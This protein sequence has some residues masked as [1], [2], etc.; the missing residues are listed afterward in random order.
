[1]KR[2]IAITVFIHFFATAYSQHT[3]CNPVNIDYRYSL[4]RPSRREAADPT[5]I[6]FK[7]EYY[8]FASKSGGYWHSKDLLN[9]DL[10][11]TKDL[12]LED[13]APTTVVVDNEIYFMASGS[14]IK[15]YKTTDP[16]SGK[17]GVVNEDFPIGLTD[18]CLFFDD[19]RRLYLYYGCSNKDPLY[20]VE[21]DLKNKLN[22]IGKPVAT[23]YGNNKEHGWDNPGDYNENAVAAPWVEGSWMNKYHGKYYLQYATP[24]T[25]FK[26]Y[27]DV[28]YV[29]DLPLGPFKLQKSNPF[30]YKPEG[31]ISGAGHSSTFCDL[32]ANYWHI[33]TMTISKI[34]WF[35]RR[36]GLFP[37][38]FDNDATLY[39]NTSFGDYPHY[40]PNKKFKN[41][42]DL[43]T[44]WMLL[45]YK[46]TVE[47][48]SAIDSLPSK[49]AVD[50]NV[51]TYWSAKSGNKGEWLCIDLENQYDVYALQ[52]NFADHNTNLLG[53]NYGSAYQ[54]VV[55]YSNDKIQWKTLINKSNNTEDH[56]H[57]YIELP[58]A[59]NARYLKIT[60]CHVP[61]GTFALNGFRV[62]GK[63]KGKLPTQVK[64]FTIERSVTDRKTVKIRWNKVPNA[65]G[66]NIR[67]GIAKDK[68]HLNYQ[69]YT[70]TLISIHSLDKNTDYYF[71]VDSFNEN[72][73]TKG[74]Q[75][76]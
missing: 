50:E 20:A 48:S 73:I 41:A 18:P 68:L 63:G 22:P 10:I 67:Y 53:R 65:V 32:Y 45:S 44:G 51:R 39:T 52:I 43:F 25:Q 57:D 7:N 34:D 31:F 30:S 23:I 2:L 60:N 47:V 56:P 59:I 38:G 6:M 15:I 16:K 13:Y 28:A 12:P 36:L 1:M 21:L 46:K 71:T 69:V 42:G 66:Y 35:E 3:Y 4:S 24:G 76:H 37:S 74:V 62:F 33:V 64:N 17:W 75:I 54:Y 70:V 58:K 27:A 11:T 5:M 19:D 9:W 8:L 26:S 14:H 61:G 40:I 55:Q 72:G 49:N 29:S